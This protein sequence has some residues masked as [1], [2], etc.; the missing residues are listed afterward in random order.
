MGRTYPAALLLPLAMGWTCSA[1]AL[2]LLLLLLSILLLLSVLSSM[3]RFY[4][5]I[6]YK[7]DAA[8]TLAEMMN[9]PAKGQGPKLEDPS[10]WL[11]E[12]QLKVD[13]NVVSN[14][15]ISLFS[16][17]STI[18]FDTSTARLDPFRKACNIT[19]HFSFYYQV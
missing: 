13:N 4:P 17:S 18:D 5:N 15:G 9:K 6:K 3:Q 11:P 12:E 10:T 14:C 1:A 7:S 8:A 2:L 19:T 16:I